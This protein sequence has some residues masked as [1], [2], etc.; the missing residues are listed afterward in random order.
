MKKL[1]LFLLILTG[2]TF[3][4]TYKDVASA[5]RDTLST[6]R[7]AK[8]TLY[9]KPTTAG[10]GMFIT[11]YTTSSS[12][13]LKVDAKTIKTSDGYEFWANTALWDMSADTTVTSIIATTTPK[14][15]MVLDP[16]VI[17]IRLGTADNDAYTRFIVAIK[18]FGR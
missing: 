8:D 14:T 6:T 2:F 3:G 13:T 12:D 11:I 18:K 16:A 4:Q 1:V 15:Y 9:Y 10:N 5:I 17:A 7:G